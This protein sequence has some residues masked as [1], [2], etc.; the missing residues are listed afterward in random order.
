MP[1]ASNEVKRLTETYCVRVL[2]IFR[3][4]VNTYL[5]FS[6]EELWQQIIRPVTC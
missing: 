2:Q 5:V 6:E 1:S 4:D 3:R